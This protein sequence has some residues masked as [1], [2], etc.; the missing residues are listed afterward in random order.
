MSSSSVQRRRQCEF[1][2]AITALTNGR[3]V[4]TWGNSGSSFDIRAR[5]V[6]ADGDPLG[7]DFLI[8][9]D[10]A[11]NQFNP[12]AAGLTGGGFVVTW[13]DIAGPTQQVRGRLFAADGSAGN[14]FVVSGQSGQ[15]Q[16]PAV[17]ALA[18]G[19]FVVSWFDETLD[20]GFGDVL[21]RIYNSD[22][23]P[24]TAAFTVPLA[25]GAVEDRPGS[26]RSQAA[27]SSSPSSRTMRLRPA[28]SM[29]TVRRSAANSR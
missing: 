7:S 28:S 14:E 18:D 24:A 22:G 16:Q 10:T 2:P 21:A 19:R 20:N 6:D 12:I 8:P 11:S 17:T 27:A 1:D 9:A 29:Q 3:F 4:V 13:K 23:S 25:A 15:A 26:R 5:L